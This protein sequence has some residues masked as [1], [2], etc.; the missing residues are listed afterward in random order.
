MT[1]KTVF[2]A[3]ALTAATA[4]TAVP[5]VYTNEA[6]FSAAVANEIGYVFHFADGTSLGTS[7]QLGP[8]AFGVNEALFGFADAYGTSY[9]GGFGDLRIDAT[10]VAVG[11]HFGSYNGDQTVTYT[12]GGI[13][14]TFVAPAPDSTTFIG[15][16][17]VTPV[18][19]TFTNVRELDT[20]SFT[21]GD[22]IPAVVAVPEPAS[23][24]LLVAGFGVVG[25]MARR[26]RTAVAA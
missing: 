7:Y 8:V 15:F 1:F 12:V 6:A 22:Q 11:L 24:A 25:A 2:F 5:T 16:V 20:I 26:R 4:A 23:W 14:G 3:A 17:D 19:V 18:S 10:T 9:L 13:T 21:T